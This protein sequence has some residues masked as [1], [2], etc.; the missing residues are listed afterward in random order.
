M[1]K[2][3]PLRVMFHLL[4][5]TAGQ[6]EFRSMQDQWIREGRGFILVYAVSNTQSFAEVRCGWL[7]VRDATLSLARL[8][9]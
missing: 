8:L 9:C 5:D 3:E 4:V 7:T 1:W 6:E 2:L